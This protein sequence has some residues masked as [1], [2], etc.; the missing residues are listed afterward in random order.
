MSRN[1]G[2]SVSVRYVPVEGAFFA[3]KNFPCHLYRYGAAL[4]CLLG[5]VYNNG[6]A[7]NQHQSSHLACERECNEQ[8]M[9]AMP[10]DELLIDT[11]TE[12]AAFS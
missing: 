3:Y 2:K 5:C 10:V 12:L 1:N 6:D 9:S 7:G 11:N 8:F 4:A